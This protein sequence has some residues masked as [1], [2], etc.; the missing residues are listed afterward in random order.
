MNKIM[1]LFKSLLQSTIQY[2]TIAI[3]L[4]AFVASLDSYAIS[5]DELIAENKLT[6][7]TSI[8]QHE[9]QIVGQPLVI[10]IEVATSRWFAKG[11]KIENFELADSIILANSEI[12]IN[13]SKRVNGQT[14]STQTREITLYPRRNGEYKVPAI[15]VQ[16]SINTESDGIVEGT[17]E[18]EPQQ[19][20]ISLPET[21]ANIEHF[22][23]SP[24]VK[25]EVAT[26][27]ENNDGDDKNYSVGSAITKTITIAAK[28]V[29][30]MMIPP[31]QQMELTGLSIYQKTPQVFDK[32]NRGDL[33]GTRIESF[34]YIFEQEGKYEIPEQ[35]IFWWNTNNNQL[36]EIIIPSLLF[37]V[38]KSITSI[39]TKTNP[40]HIN[41]KQS[42]W[43]I[44]IVSIAI[45]AF[46]FI[47][48]HKNNLIRLYANVTHLEQRTIKKAFLQE[49]SNHKYISA[50]DHLY[51][52]SLLVGVNLDQ[53]K[54]TQILSLNKLAFDNNNQSTQFTL[55]DAKAL[56]KGLTEN[57][58]IICNRLD[59]EKTIKL[60]NQS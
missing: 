11:T 22:I 14:W 7:E 46:V 60:N 55:Q 34:T 54:S 28:S 41:F 38:G 45:C 23:V 5:L 17:I 51:K 50:I 6:I 33:V 52:Y 56:L 35:V 47:F 53:V 10:A 16:I 25:L 4:I 57:K 39:E 18:T 43:I 12:S 44:V 24:Q 9:Q 31:L 58:S 8:K 36:Q 29:P 20:T 19:F 48:R 30:A 15:T 32:S 40:L 42:I 26:D 3:I 1:P 2:S 13:G 21:L 37:N 49:V 27:N 59:V